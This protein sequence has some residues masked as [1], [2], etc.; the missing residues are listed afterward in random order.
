MYPSIAPLVLY[1]ASIAESLKAATQQLHEAEAKNKH[2][3]ELEADLERREDIFDS[4]VRGQL[5]CFSLFSYPVRLVDSKVS[6]L[7]W[8]S[9]LTWQRWNPAALHVVAKQTFA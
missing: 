7:M 3:I 5:V 1:R 8:Q 4:Q 6:L 9:W 2:L